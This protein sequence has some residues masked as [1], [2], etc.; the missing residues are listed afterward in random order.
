MQAVRNVVGLWT[1]IKSAPRVGTE[2]SPSQM[3]AVSG[4]ASS[5]TTQTQ[6]APVRGW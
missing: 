2:L 5:Y 6:D 3:A 4:G 1:Q